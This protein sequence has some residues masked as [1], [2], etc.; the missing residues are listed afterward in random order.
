M[1]E[2]I[3]AI[4]LTNGKCVRLRQGDYSQKTEYSTDPVNVALE[5][6]KVGFHRLHIVDL[7]GARSKHVVNDGVLRAIT[8][9]TSL[10]VDFGGGI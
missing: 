3:P 9:A 8:R 2:L 5:L 6:E 10:K 4:D 1:I 7:D